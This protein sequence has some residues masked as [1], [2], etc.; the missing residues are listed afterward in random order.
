MSGAPALSLGVDTLCWHLRLEAGDLSLEDLLEEASQA[1]AEYV[2]LT[3]HHARRREPE[4]LS[5]LAGRA[6]DLGLR[7]LASGDFLGGARFGDPPRAAAERVVGWLERA[8]A[9]GSRSCA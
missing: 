7:V 1:G 6:G 9:L 5:R 3:R 4:E 8:V 2:Q